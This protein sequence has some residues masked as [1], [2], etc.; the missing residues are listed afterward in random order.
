MTILGG[1]HR[2][3]FLQRSKGGGGGGDRGDR[4]LVRDSIGAN[5]APIATIIPIIIFKS[6]GLLGRRI[7]GGGDLGSGV[8]GTSFFPSPVALTI[9]WFEVSLTEYQEGLKLRLGSP[10]PIKMKGRV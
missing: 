4:T 3:Q 8:I 1:Q 2:F 9:K 7:L 6:G 5:L 10:V